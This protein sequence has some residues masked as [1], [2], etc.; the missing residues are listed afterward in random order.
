MKRLTTLLLV[1]FLFFLCPTLGIGQTNFSDSLELANFYNAVCNTNSCV[2]DWGLNQPIDTWE[3]IGLSNGRIDSLDLED[4]GL[5]GSLPNL[6][7]PYLE[8]LNLNGNNLDD[9]IPN[10]TYLVNLRI[11]YLNDNSFSGNAPSFDSLNNLRKL[12]LDGNSLAGSIPDFH[13]PN[14]LELDLSYN[15]LE[16]NIP[17][18]TNL[19]NLE[20]LYLHRNYSLEGVIP[21]FNLSNLRYLDLSYN[22]LT[23][24]IPDFDNLINLISLDLFGNELTGTVPNFTNLL[25]LTE[26]NIGSN[27]LTGVIPQYE[28]LVYL[29]Y[30]NIGRNDLSGMIPNFSNL[31]NLEDLNLERN[32]LTGTIPDFIE[33]LN[34]QRLYLGGNDSLEGNIPNFSYL[35]DLIHLHLDG[36]QLSGTIPNFAQSGL[37]ELY[38]DNNQLVDTIPNFNLPALRELNLGYNQLTGTI[39]SF[40]LP[41]LELLNLEN[42]QLTGM[43]PDFASLGDLEEIDLTNN[44][45][46]GC[47][48]P[49]L[50]NLCAIDYDFRYNPNL[51]NNGDFYDFCINSSGVCPDIDSLELVDF[52]LTTCNSNCILNWDFSTPVNSWNG[53]ITSNNKVVELHLDNMGLSGN[54]PNLNLPYLRTL[55]LSGNQLSGSIPDFN[56]LPSLTSLYL[57]YNVLSGTI[58]DF[59]SLCSLKILALGGNQL[60]ASIPVFTG[61]PNLVF[62]QL[63]YN[64]LTGSIPDF[65]NLPNLLFLYLNNNQ[66]SGCFPTSLN[67]FCSLSSV[68]YNFVNNPG[69]PNNGDFEAFCL[70]GAGSCF[71][72]EP[73]S[74]SDSLELISFYD[75]TCIGCPLYWNRNAP[76]STWEGISLSNGRVSEINLSQKEL[77]GTIPDIDLSEL[78]QLDLRDNYL[79]GTLPDFSG[80]PN[81]SVF[82]VGG[83]QNIFVFNNNMLSGEIPNFTG[84]PNLIVLILDDNDFAGEIP[85]FAYMPNL[86]TFS[87]TQ[88]QLSGEIP[89]FDNLLN[90][91]YLNLGYNQLSGQIPDFYLPNLK[92]LYLRNCQLTGG[93]PDFSGLNNLEWLLLSSNEGLGGTIPNFS[94]LPNLRTFQAASC[95]LSGEVPNFTGLNNLEY[96]QLLRNQLTGNI[97]DFNLPNLISLDLKDNQLTGTIPNF[98]GMPLL[99]NLELDNNQLNGI[100]PNFLYTPLLIDL[101]LGDNELTGVVMDFTQLPNLER[102]NLRGNQLNGVMPNLMNL[103]DLTYFNV[104]GNNL[105]DTIPNFTGLPNLEDLYLEGNDFTGGITNFTNL[106]KLEVLSLSSGKLTGSIPDFANLYSLERLYLDNN[107]LTGV[108]PDFATLTNLKTIEVQGNELS[109]IIPDFTFLPLINRVEIVNNQFSFED[110]DINFNRN[111]LINSFEYSPQYHGEVQSYIVEEGDTLTI[112]LSHPLSGNNNQNVDYEWQKND[113]EINNAEDSIYGVI[114]LQLNNLGK[115]T[116]HM[117]DASRV[118][119]LE[120]ISKPIYVMAIGYDLYGQKVEYS[121][122][123]VE[124]DDWADKEFYEEEY[125]YEASGWV[126]DSCS[127]NRLLYLWQFPND[128]IALQVLLDINTKKEEQT[129][130]AEIDGGPNSIFTLVE[131]SMCGIG[132]DWEGTYTDIYPDSVLVYIMDSGM[133][134]GGW[135]SSPYLMNTAPLDSCYTMAASGYNYTDTLGNFDTNYIDSLG[136]GTFGF[137]AVIEDL[138]DYMDLKVVPLKVFD[139]KGEGTLFKFVCALYHAI[140][141]DADI[142]NISAGY[143]GQ[144]SSILE[145]AI[146]LAQEKGVFIVTAVGNEGV[147]ID[148]FPQYPAYYAGDFYETVDGDT[149]HY[150][151]VISVASINADSTLSDFSNYGVKSA[152][153]SAYGEDMTGYGIGG[154]EVISSG[155]SIATFYVTHE[156]AVEIAKNKNLDYETIWSNFENSSLVPSPF[157][158]DSTRTGKQLDIELFY[159]CDPIR[160]LSGNITEGAYQA[161]CSV[162]FSGIISEGNNVNFKAGENI[163]LESGAEIREGAT[164]TGEI[165]PCDDDGN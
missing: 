36:N 74:I 145:G 61:L 44:E 12:D 112:G 161:G 75:T 158:V 118:P 38:L 155:T 24:D 40:N 45:L 163:I 68:Y 77:N 76:V 62:L 143:S 105:T 31:T 39:P 51:P 71:V 82:S 101:E 157:T 150:D 134:S 103:S 37:R 128:T 58:P 156:L 113:I 146:Q 10:F 109:G 91:E 160:I 135:D 19:V 70:N 29:E 106:P 49:S 46:C 66:L 164:F 102:L 50:I 127:C 28:N 87:A 151:N 55:R 41:D 9:T 100:I 26:L 97:P 107:K 54:I 57:A 8:Y 131:S 132:W 15:D 125:L 159:I 81:L 96:M 18:F 72:Y 90:L 22:D 110:M 78:I 3:G 147:N 7:L 83:I 124:F 84:L 14:L 115:Y 104:S 88:N 65:D 60:N 95:Q 133:D 4:V 92:D 165:G 20:K 138:N 79:T 11:L 126:G 162:K 67:R 123:I 152:T 21:D 94:G 16:G 137:R 141:H 34:L 93:I 23:G 35:E 116:L 52:Y 25:N 59:S 17:A 108:I 120:I 64:Y 48:S 85:N 111:I 136:H 27:N 69:L 142:I 139:E 13:L 121:Q 117:T 129:E 98:S 99:T 1:A 80:L 2:L 148:S 89:S 73:V 63:S 32:N 6:N 144:P 33:L 114:N 30:L 42:N 140:D 149:I 122:I 5:L 47:F 86:K 56:N 130:D 119:D 153:L 154:V 43:I 53:V